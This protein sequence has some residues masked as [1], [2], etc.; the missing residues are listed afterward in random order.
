MKRTHTESCPIKRIITSIL[1]F[2]FTSNAI[3]LTGKT[4]NEDNYPKCQYDTQL[5]KINLPLIE[6]W[7]VDGKEPTGT[8]INAP[9]G[10][11]GITLVDNDYVQGR[12]K[13]SIKDSLIYDSKEVGMKI[14]LRGNTSSTGTKKNLQNKTIK[15]G[16]LIVQRRGYI[17]R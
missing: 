2:F 7:T 17:Q 16:R 15:E 6:I 13:I 8:H 14:R 10:L 3:T 1:L 11:W 5:R 4:T 12:M 9:E